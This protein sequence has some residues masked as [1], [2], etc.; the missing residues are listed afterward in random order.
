VMFAL[1]GFDAYGLDVSETGISEAKKFAA[2]ELKE[3]QDFNFGSFRGTDKT[4]VGSVSW[5]TDDFFADWN[6]GT[7]FDIIYDYTVR[8]GQLFNFAS[9]H[10]KLTKI[11]PMCVI[12]KHAQKLGGPNG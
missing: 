11:V 1:H 2:S 6:K 10:S 5:F 8:H 3:P 9:F 12:S 4:D 7:Q